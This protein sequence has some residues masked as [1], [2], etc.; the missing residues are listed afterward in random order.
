MNRLHFEFI[1]L[2]I[3]LVILFCILNMTFSSRNNKG[4]F[5]LL[6]ISC[7]YIYCL[8]NAGI[9]AIFVWRKTSLVDFVHKVNLIFL[10]IPPL[11]LANIQLK[12]NKKNISSEKYKKIF[13][14]SPI[15]YISV[16]VLYIIFFIMPKCFLSIIFNV[17]VIIIAYFYCFIQHGISYYF[18]QEKNSPVLAIMI[19]SIIITFEQIV[20]L[21]IISYSTVNIENFHPNVKSDW[22]IP[23]VISMF[24]IF[25]NYFQNYWLKFRKQIDEIQKD[26]LENKFEKVKNEKNYLVENKLNEE[27]IS[28]IN[29]LKNEVKNNDKILSEDKEKINNTI[30]NLLNSINLLHFTKSVDFTKKNLENYF[31][32]FELNKFINSILNRE[33]D[34]LTMKNLFVDYKNLIVK[35]IYVKSYPEFITKIIKLLFL[36]VK[37]VEILNSRIVVET[38]FIYNIF[39]LSI[40]FP[41]E[42]SDSDLINSVLNFDFI[43]SSKEYLDNKE[44]VKVLDDLGIYLFVVNQ[45]SSI[46]SGSINVS[47]FKNRIKFSLKIPMTVCKKNE[48]IQEINSYNIQNQ[49]L[50]N[51]EYSETIFIINQDYD[52]RIEFLNYFRKFY[53]VYTFNN[54]ES[55]FEI[56]ETKI[57]DFLIFSTKVGNS[58]SIDF[59]KKIK[60]DSKLSAIPIFAIS[61]NYSENLENI[62]L[63]EGVFEVINEPF[64]MENLFYKIN[65]TFE[66]KRKFLENFV[67]KLTKSIQFNDVKENDLLNP[68]E[69][70][71]VKAE[72]AENVQNLSESKSEIPFSL[73]AKFDSANL[74][75]TEYKIASLIADGKTDKEIAQILN[76]SSG[77]VSVHNKKIFKKQNIH[78]RKELL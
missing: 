12:L 23:E 70:K 44:L 51:P 59:V 38:S 27:I 32:D 56:A 6:L 15:F 77:T 35:N 41:G 78:T 18:K 52:E 63:K 65:S 21:L 53:K 57:P 29:I 7:F 9:L 69:K 76:I 14:L 43:D 16:P 73:K 71:S 67:K 5:Y 40:D 3:Y 11:F 33:I 72:N 13:K 17:V 28:K 4:L 42:N 31:V 68:P 66:I 22:N 58:S 48:N 1:L 54:F 20:K 39:T 8:N 25:Y 2:G 62:L 45:L 50:E 60:S 74:T 75:K 55:F 24:L 61:V 37:N 47:F 19:M 26:V 10:L 34:E 49:F 46:I 64:L 36:I 30:E